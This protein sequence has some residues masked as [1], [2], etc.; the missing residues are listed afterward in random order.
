MGTLEAGGS[1]TVFVQGTVANSQASYVIN[2]ATVTTSTP[3]LNLAN[4][5]AVLITP[6][7]SPCHDLQVC[8]RICGE[9]ACMNKPLEFRVYLLNRGVS[10]LYH[11]TV[12]LNSA[13]ALSKLR[14]SL[15]YGKTWRRWEQHY[16]LQELEAAG[17]VE[18]LF[19][20]IVRDTKERY[21]KN[22]VKV[23]V[24]TETSDEWTS[25]VRIPIG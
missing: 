5:T 22:T 23:Y 11:V 19:K 24:G 9:Y 2:V 20:G 25:K 10:S 3:E 4:N 17:S 13:E 21:L 15:D 7:I 1:I 14:Y 6:I 12:T 8:Q 18:M 16:R